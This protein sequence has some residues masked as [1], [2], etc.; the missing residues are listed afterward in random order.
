MH[1]RILG[2]LEVVDG[3]CS[4]DVGGAK[5]RSLFAA[6][7]IH[8]NTVV[9]ADRL[10]DCLWEEEPPPTAR[11]ALQVYVA[12]LRKALGPTRVLTKGP[13][14]MLR[15]EPGEL[16]RE[17]FERLVEQGG[18][19]GLR[20]ALALWRGPPLADVA[21]R[22]FARAEIG[23]LEELRAA[24]VETRIQC[25]LAEGRHQELVGELEALVAEHPARERLRGQLMLALYRSGRQ[26]EALEAY[27]DVRR[28]LVEE[29]GIEPSRELRELHQA[30]LNQEVSLDLVGE[31]VAAS[32]PVFV[33]RRR[34][35]AALLGDL[36]E[37]FAG[38]GRLAL[39]GGEPGIGNTRLAEELAGRARKR[40]GLVLVGHGWEAGGAPRYWPW[41]QALR[42]YVRETEPHALRGKLGAGAADLAQLLPELREL[43]P[44]LPEH[45]HSS[46]RSAGSAC[47]RRWPSFSRG[48]PTPTRSCSSSTTST[49]PTRLP[50]SCSVSWPARSRAAD[51]LCSASSATSTRR[52]LSPSSPPWGRS[53]ACRRHARLRSP[54]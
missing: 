16:D 21:D 36:D 5:R 33:G 22:R 19:E 37:T 38:R 18:P 28:T 3:D 15:V 45:P 27:Q 35:L 40:G 20:E 1:F 12:R 25:D 42:A 44:D 53:R 2:P 23:R 52:S 47:S 50:F 51:S 43:L 13:G 17:R 9:S 49:R 31:E 11:K 10:I 24:A 6:L 4:V 48:P 32:G 8:A 54:G 39:V 26:A 41:V 7:L 30:I 29:L 34:E 14:Y 46:R